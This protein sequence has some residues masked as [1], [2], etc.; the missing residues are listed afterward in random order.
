MPLDPKVR[1]AIFNKY[2]NNEKWEKELTQIT[3]EKKRMANYCGCSLFDLENLPLILY[4]VI[5]RDSW[6]ES[7]NATEEGRQVLKDIW[8]LQQTSADLK[9]IRA[10]G[11]K[12]V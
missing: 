2:F 1:E 5:K 9:K 10:K 11:V 4:L 12:Q 6:L 7:M 3:A 8:R